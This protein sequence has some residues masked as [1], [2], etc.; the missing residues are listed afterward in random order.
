MALWLQHAC[1]ESP[2]SAP[3]RPLAGSQYHMNRMYA[4]AI[5][6]YTLIVKNRQYASAGRLRVN[7]GNIHFQEKKYLQVGALSRA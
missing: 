7:M 3:S 1:R 2:H 4:E 6:T 5:N